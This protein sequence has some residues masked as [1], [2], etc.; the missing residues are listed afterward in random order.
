MSDF[1]T[2][3]GPLCA[4]AIGALIG[5]CVVHDNKAIPSFKNGHVSI[6]QDKQVLPSE[7]GGWWVSTDGTNWNYVKQL[8]SSRHE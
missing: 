7:F 4:F 3:L 1:E 8:N 6:I 5:G 2:T